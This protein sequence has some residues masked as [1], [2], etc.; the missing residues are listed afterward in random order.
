MKNIKHVA[1]YL[2]LSRDEEKLGIEK[3][4][5]NHRMA[6]TEYA[7]KN[8][9]T[10]EIFEEIASSR[11]IEGRAEMKRLLEFVKKKSFDAVLVMDIDR[12][13]RN[14]FDA[15]A[16][17]RIL[18]ENDTVIATITKT[19][20]FER[21]ED[22]LLLGI[23]SLVAAQEYKQIQ[24]RMNNRKIINAH[25]GNWINGKPP[26]GYLR[27]KNTKKLEVDNEKTLVVKLIFEI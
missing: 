12:L 24:K 25:L 21:D 27:N 4:L 2:R 9:W 14:E 11:N 6:L 3:A 17:K 13:S 18:L 1:I 19:Y 5:A 10:Y 23:Q 22:S 16:I 15:S 7:N 26:Y 20:D 8:N